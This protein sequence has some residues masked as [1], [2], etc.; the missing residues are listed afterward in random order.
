[1]RVDE[2]SQAVLDALAERDLPA[3][4]LADSEHPLGFGRRPRDD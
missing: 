2:V 3:R 1:V 4:E